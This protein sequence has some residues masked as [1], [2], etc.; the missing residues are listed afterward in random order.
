MKC[1]LTRKSLGVHGGVW[2]VLH[3][4]RPLRNHYCQSFTLARAVYAERPLRELLLRDHTVVLVTHHV[5]LVLPG[6]YY[7]IRMLDGRI[8]T[9]GPVGELHAQAVLYDIAHDETA[10]AAKEEQAVAEAEAKP[11]D[12]VN[13]KRPLLWVLP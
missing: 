4:W 3:L 10:E 5:E 1:S 13:A 8:D 9:Q 6:T 11:A 7:I 12:D 2:R